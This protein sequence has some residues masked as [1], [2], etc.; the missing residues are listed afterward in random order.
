[1]RLAGFSSALLLAAAANASSVSDQITVGSTRAS[2]Q[3]LR[4]GSISNLLRG[5]FDVGGSWT[6]SADAQITFQEGVP[7]PSGTPLSFQEGGGMVGDFS[8]SLD[9]EAT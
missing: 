1:M 7:G 9:W 8:A 4:S 2:A 5:S 6:A 3:T